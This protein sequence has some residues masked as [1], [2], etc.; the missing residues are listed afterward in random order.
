[1]I[2]ESTPYFCVAVVAVGLE[3]VCELSDTQSLVVLR[4]RP[5]SVRVSHSAAKRSHKA[6]KGTQGTRH[7]W[8]VPPVEN[9]ECV[10]STRSLDRY[11]MEIGAAV[12]L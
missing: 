5:K 4:T 12:R 2:Q 10:R 11:S 3:L 8:H 6:H 1:M 9:F 7:G